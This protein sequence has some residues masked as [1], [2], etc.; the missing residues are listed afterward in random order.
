MSVLEITNTLQKTTKN[1]WNQKQR[2]K[3][4][5]SGE[6]TDSHDLVL[7]FDHMLVSYQSHIQLFQKLWKINIPVSLA[8][9]RCYQ[10]VYFALLA[11]RQ[12][13]H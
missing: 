11:N 13:I 12:K 2:S 5:K 9:I 3:M 4:L 6:S 1:N 7:L 8:A 10:R